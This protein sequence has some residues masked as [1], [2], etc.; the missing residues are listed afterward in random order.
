MT[1][2]ITY[3]YQAGLAALEALAPDEALRHFSQAWAFFQD[4]PNQDPLL[5][6]DL[7]IGLGTAQRQA[8]MPAYRETL[9]DAA[10]RAQD[11]GDTDRLVAAA[12][13]NNRGVVSS[14]GRMDVERISILEA[15][16]RALPEE[17][18][19]ERALLVGTLC[20]EL[21]LGT[22]LSR[23]I[24]LAD[25]AQAI[26]RRLGDDETSVVVACLVHAPLSVPWLHDAAPAGLHRGTGARRVPRGPGAVV[27]RPH[28]PP[29]HGAQGR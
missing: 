13:G 9:L 1:K 17:D 2:A 27:P 19:R 5:G 12:L 25:E 20:A 18:S 10:Q 8:G 7:L 26:A 4:D 16:L 24:E 29:S 21:T 11:L 23:R 15:A 28:H 3:G 6:V 22:P 14:S